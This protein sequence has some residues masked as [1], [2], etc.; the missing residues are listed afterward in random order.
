M[1]GRVLIIDD[2]LS[3]GKTI[4]ESTH[5]IEGHGAQVVGA[6]IA[7]DREES[8]DNPDMTA[9]DELTEALGFPVF[10]IARISALVAEIKA[11]DYSAYPEAQ[12][13]LQYV[14]S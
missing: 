5:M 6:V 14:D 1:Q 9:R 3:S 4:R 11:N 8:M 13:L 7:L 10:S 12:A 2:V